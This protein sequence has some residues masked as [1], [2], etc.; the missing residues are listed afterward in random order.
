MRK[1][2]IERMKTQKSE[3]LRF[4]T[5]ETVAMS[6]ALHLTVAKRKELL[7]LEEELRQLNNTKLLDQFFDL[8]QHHKLDMTAT[9]LKV[10]QEAYKALQKE[11]PKWLERLIRTLE[12]KDS[13]LKKGRANK[14]ENLVAKRRN[15]KKL[16]HHRKR[17]KNTLAILRVRNLLKRGKIKIEDLQT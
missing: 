8:Q 9:R 13:K 2:Q 3:D 15:A 11:E 6:H 5:D 16:A 12:V 1:R 17:D 7:S 10:W 4:S 14:V